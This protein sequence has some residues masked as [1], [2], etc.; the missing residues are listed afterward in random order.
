M[1]ARPTSAFG[2]ILLQNHTEG[3]LEGRGSLQKC[4]FQKLRRG[5]FIKSQNCFRNGP[6]FVMKMCFHH[7]NT[8]FNPVFS[9]T[10]LVNSRSEGGRRGGTEFAGLSAETYDM[11]ASAIGG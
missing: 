8:A 1:D 3:L 2:P 11:V 9:P 6:L 4:I 10:F 5:L 7:E